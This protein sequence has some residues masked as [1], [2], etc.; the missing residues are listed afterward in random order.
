MLGGRRIFIGLLLVNGSEEKK[1]N[2]PD[3]ENQENQGENGEGEI[4]PPLLIGDKNTKYLDDISN[5]LVE[6]GQRFDNFSIRRMLFGSS[7]TDGIVRRALLENNNQI[8]KLFSESTHDRF[9]HII[10]NLNSTKE[11]ISEV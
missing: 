2:Q 6:Y 4:R 10:R 1:R 9:T 3:N 8:Y 7:D 11:K 5:Q